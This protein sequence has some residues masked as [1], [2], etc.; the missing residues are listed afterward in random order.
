[1]A[2]RN[3]VEIKLL[4]VTPAEWHPDYLAAVS[5]YTE[6]GP[7]PGTPVTT[8]ELARLQPQIVGAQAIDLTLVVLSSGFPKTGGVG[9]TV[10]YYL[11]G[12]T[13]AEVRG[14][15]PPLYISDWMHIGSQA[16]GI[17]E[18]AAVCPLCGRIAMNVGLVRATYSPYDQSCSAHD[19]LSGSA[20][21]AANRSTAFAFVPGTERLIAV[22]DGTTVY[23]SD[24]HGT[25]YVDTGSDGPQAAGTGAPGGVAWF[26]QSLAFDGAGRLLWCAGAESD[27]DKMLCASSDQGATWEL[28]RE[29]IADGFVHCVAPHPD[30][31]IAYV[32]TNLAGNNVLFKR[33]GGAY[34]DPDTQ[35]GVDV[36]GDIGGDADHLSV[37]CDENGSIWIFLTMPGADNTVR[38]YF[39]TDGGDTWTRGFDLSYAESVDEPG[40]FRVV[41]HAWGGLAGVW[42]YPNS[43]STGGYVWLGGWSAPSIDDHEWADGTGARDDGHYYPVD[44]PANQGWTKTGTATGTLVSG[45]GAGYWKVESTGAGL[46]GYWA[47][48][49]RSS[50]TSTAS[51]KFIVQV[52]DDAG[53]TATAIAT[54]A[55]FSLSA[56]DGALVRT[57]IL[58]VDE[59]GFRVWDD[60]AAAWV[61]SKSLLNMQGRKTYFRMAIT[62]SGTVV[63][64]YRQNENTPTKWTSVTSST[65]GTA[66]SALS[67]AVAQW[68]QLLAG[69][70][71]VVTWWRL[72]NARGRTHVAVSGYSQTGV[73]L[74]PYS[75]PIPDAHNPSV[76]FDAEPLTYRLSRLTLAGGPAF[77]REEYQVDTD[78]AYPIEHAFPTVNPNSDRRWESRASGVEQTALCSL[79]TDHNT[80]PL[81]GPFLGAALAVRNAN[82]RYIELVAQ[83]AAGGALVSMGTMDLATGFSS[84]AYTKGGG[85]ILPNASYAGRFIKA[86]EL[87]GGYLHTGA[88]TVSNLILDNTAGWWSTD[89]AVQCSL[90][91]AGD[92]SALAASGTCDIVWPHGLYYLINRTA[93]AYKNW[94]WR[95]AVTAGNAIPAEHVGY[96]GWIHLFGLRA[97]GKRWGLGWETVTAPNVRSVTDDRGTDW[98]ERKGPAR[99]TLT[100]SWDEGAKADR[101]RA[102]AAA[103]GDWVS[104][105]GY[106]STNG[107]AA[108]DDVSGQLDGLYAASADGARPWLVLKKDVTAV[109]AGVAQETITDQSLY[110]VAYPDSDVRT[111]VP[112]G[113]EGTNEF[114]LTGPVRFVEIR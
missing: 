75:Y 70:N 74:G 68:G 14:Y 20:A 17:G 105:T 97:P 93:T 79:H 72:V 78:F 15:T 66:A 24:D 60:V 29:W 36:T 46:Q 62:A 98:R 67:N 53:L 8:S 55:G 41:P 21:T 26:G 27:A 35:D 39:S 59:A 54:G 63:V 6:R 96:R 16:A 83:L 69:V 48:T 111:A 85:R 113:L 112:R 2:A 95:I 61:T 90:T 58:Y 114:E 43:S 94:G 49:V 25:T 100:V 22:A 42:G 84:V 110:L 38:T 23:Y 76:H 99:R 89:A 87:R 71:D 45:S 44:D 107:I 33:L 32:A 103:G 73:G 86:G 57:A 10:G 108:R 77:S 88:G 52:N 81:G 31:S 9:C 28:V 19:A 50:A 82:V 80:Y 30:G 92:V 37:A 47:R 56:R 40:R 102:S 65:L 101:W 51:A 7:R 13:I 5:S 18:D 4:G 104:P 12:E 11:D 109:V 64:H 3:A 34:D 106:S 91:L 1:M